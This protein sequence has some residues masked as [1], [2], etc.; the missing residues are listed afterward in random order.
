MALQLHPHLSKHFQ[1]RNVFEEVL[2]NQNTAN[3]R[4]RKGRPS[5]RLW[6]TMGDRKEK[7]RKGLNEKKNEKIIKSYKLNGEGV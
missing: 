4:R 1:L 2:K 3:G 7:K 5:L 6:Y